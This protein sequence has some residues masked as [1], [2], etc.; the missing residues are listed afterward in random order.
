M[1]AAERMSEQV[2]VQHELEDK[3]E[4]LLRVAQTAGVGGVLLATHHNIAWITGGRS[5]RVD[6]SREAGTARLLFTADGRR[7]VL[8]NA[9]EMPRMLDEVLAGLDFEPVEYPWTD[10][11]D[12]GFAVAT[13]KK[14]IGRSDVS[15]GAD[16]PLPETLSIEGAIARTRALLTEAEVDRYRALGRDA[17][18]TLGNVCRTL[19]PGDQELEIAAAVV[20]A[21]AGVRARAIVALVGSDER[22]RRYRHPVAT[23][24]R[25]KHVVMLALCAERDGLV[26][27][28][29]RIVSAGAAPRDLDIRTRATATVFG[30]LLDATRPGATGAQLYGVAAAAYAAANFPGE[31]QKHHQGGAIGYRAREWVAHP[32]SAEVVQ[33]RQA[34]AWNP[35]ITGTKIEDTALV[36]GDRIEIITSTPDWPAIA[37]D[38]RDR[39]LYASDVWKLN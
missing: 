10:D 38:T 14:A 30:R 34:F 36:V 17:G 3:V 12:P 35:T 20:Q 33:T 29:S 2:I 7:R 13:A 4:R 23:A 26:V 6:S 5:N 16:W 22:L 21:V 18:R 37:L 28:L 19:T 9:I 39:P 32:T 27:S 1:P 24:A 15:I 8:A 11:Q 25:W 31:E